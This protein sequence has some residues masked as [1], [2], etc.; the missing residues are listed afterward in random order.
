M[1]LKSSVPERNMFLHLWTDLLKDK[2]VD[3]APWDLENGGP[4]FSKFCYLRD[5]ALHAMF[6]QINPYISPCP[7]L[8]L[9]K[10]REKI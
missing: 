9:I 1:L 5:T 8:R 2:V 4:Q 10:I 3:R 6:H 7:T